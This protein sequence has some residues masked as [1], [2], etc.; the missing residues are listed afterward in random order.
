MPESGTSGSVGTAGRQLPAVTR[1][2]LIF[3][4]AGPTRTL[5]RQTL[6]GN[7][8]DTKP[9]TSYGG[10]GLALDLQADGVAQQPLLVA[11]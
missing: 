10:L 8:N 7:Y 6:S 4:G 2:R 1:Q 11:A 9:L 3:V 5:V